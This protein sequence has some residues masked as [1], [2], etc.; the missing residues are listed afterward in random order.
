M[1]LYKRGNIYWMSFVN[2]QGIR[3]RAT[4]ETANKKLAESIYAKVVTE[5][6]EGR[7]FDNAKAKSK[8][9]DEMMRVYFEKTIDKPAT[10]E[11][12][13]GAFI[14][15]EKAF[16]GL[17]LDRITSE[18]IDDYKGNRL[19]E[20]AAHSTVLNEIRTLSHAFNTIKWRKDNPVRD[21]KRVKLRAREVDRWLTV[22]EEAKLLPKTKD[23]LYGQLEDITMLDLN[24]GMSQEEVLKLQ[25]TQIDF[26]RRTLATIRSKTLNARTIPLNNNALDILKRRA[27][28]QSLSGY[29][30]FNSVGNKHDA[31]KLKRA[32]RQ[33]VE[34]SGI[35]HFRFHDLRH[36]F[37]TRLVQRG[38]DLYKVSKLLGHKD[39]STTQRYAHHYPE[40]LRDGVE[41]LDVCHN[42]VT[43]E[44]T[45]VVREFATG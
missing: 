35:E 32:F 1:G 6:K 21:A 26:T 5:V 30:F 12:K 39:I 10:R 18:A 16:S 24:T 38:V 11:R 33:A 20:K 15:L 31:S 36:T 27:K 4:T 7:W 43:V 25:W 37:A 2:E 8:T 13:K 14:H 17:T 44:E 28:V 45:V 40:S 41:I 23:K 22:E 42:L 29:V 19:I 9:F 34:E 3:E